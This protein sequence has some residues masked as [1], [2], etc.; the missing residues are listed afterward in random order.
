MQNLGGMQTECIMGNWKIENAGLLSHPLKV[1]PH[2]I[3]NSTFCESFLVKLPCFN[4]EG[5]KTLIC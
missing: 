2:E 5:N 4:L 1:M 3:V